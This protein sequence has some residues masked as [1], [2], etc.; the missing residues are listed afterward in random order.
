MNISQD[1]SSLH[2][3]QTWQAPQWGHVSAPF[4]QG[5]VVQLSWWLKMG[6]NT[7]VYTIHFQQFAKAYNFYD[8]RTELNFPHSNGA[9]ERGV[10]TAKPQQLTPQWPNIGLVKATNCRA[11]AA[12]RHHYN[13]WHCSRPLSSLKPGDSVAVELDNQKEWCT[14]AT[15]WCK[16]NTRRCFL[17]RTSDDVLHRN[18]WHV[19]SHFLCLSLWRCQR[20]SPQWQLPLKNL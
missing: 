15:F 16:F 20:L 7:E 6:H 5:G 8:I 2:T 19:P 11:K 13:R 9:A 1:R 10:R 4:L 12:Y 14:T 17:F 18:K 3:S